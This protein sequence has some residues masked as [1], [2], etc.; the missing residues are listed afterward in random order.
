MDATMVNNIKIGGNEG[1]ILNP[2]LLLLLFTCKQ[3][4]LPGNRTNTQFQDYF[5]SLGIRLSFFGYT[6]FFEPA[7]GLVF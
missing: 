5:F 6:T 1:Y 3:L 7:L 2:M 4:Y